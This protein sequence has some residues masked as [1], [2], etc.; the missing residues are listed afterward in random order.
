MA[1]RSEGFTVIELLIAMALVGILFPAL[2]NYFLHASKEFVAQQGIIQM[3]SDAR[4]AMDVMVRELRHSYGAPTLSTTVTTGDT[5][6]FDRVEDTGRS[7]GGNTSTTL[8]DTAKVWL[9]DAFAPSAEGAY[10]L[11][12]VTGTGA[13]QSR[14]VA[15]NTA[16][17]LMV[18]AAWGVT[19]D[20][21]SLYSLTRNKG[22]TRASA[23]DHV[24]GY[25]LG[26]TAD[27][28]PLADH[29]TALTFALPDPE[30]VT[31]TLTARTQGLDPRSG[32]LRTYT[33]TETVR[34][35]N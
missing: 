24:L 9:E 29:I 32:E 23:T 1:H 17:E 5:I 7:T 27:H 19:P 13:G 21:T 31:V 26:S 4:A 35:R 16:T 18:A 22:F 25:R 33:L 14:T 11:W 2:Y 15:S 30:T 6:S 12:I 20:T 34:R 8:R 3:Q 28:T 10:R